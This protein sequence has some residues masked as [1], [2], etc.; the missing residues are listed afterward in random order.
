MTVEWFIVLVFFMMLRTSLLFLY[1]SPLSQ[2]LIYV[3]QKLY[4]VLLTELVLDWGYLLCYD[5][6]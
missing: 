2:L 3:L 1:L 6:I 5:I 4:K